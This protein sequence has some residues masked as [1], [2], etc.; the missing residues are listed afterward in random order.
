MLLLPHIRFAMSPE[1]Y[2]D[3][4]EAHGLEAW[5]Q[6]VKECLSLYVRSVEQ[7]KQT[8]YANEYLIILDLLNK[9]T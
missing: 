9:S 1:E 5:C 8:K 2:V 7:E 6:M 3:W 4:I